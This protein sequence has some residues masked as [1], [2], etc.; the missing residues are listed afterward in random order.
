MIIYVRAR[1]QS[2]FDMYIYI[3]IYAYIQVQTRIDA[4]TDFLHAHNKG[5]YRLM[6]NASY[7]HIDRYR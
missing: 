3:Y 1:G 7:L 6:W 5:S 4:F 2:K